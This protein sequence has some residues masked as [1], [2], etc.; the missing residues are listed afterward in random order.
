M[1]TISPPIA[2]AV[3]SLTDRFRGAGALER[4]PITGELTIE[5]VTAMRGTL[6]TIV[7]GLQDDEKVFRAVFGKTGTAATDMKARLVYIGTK[8]M[9]DKRLSDDELV[10]VM[11]GLAV[12][13]VA[14]INFDRATANHVQKIWAAHSQAA[15]T[16]DVHNVGQDIR[17]EVRI[18]NAYPGYAATLDAALWYVL[19]MDAPM[20]R[21]VK[22]TG[23]N[24]GA[25][26]NVFFGGVRSPWTFDWSPEPTL[27]TWG[28][29]WAERF[30]ATDERKVI[31]ALV[32]EALDVI[33]RLQDG[34]VTPPQPPIDEPIDEPVDGPGGDEPP[35]TDEPD[36]PTQR[37]PSPDDDDTGADE[38]PDEDVEDEDPDSDWD[39][40]SESES[41]APDEDEDLDEDD[42]EPETKP[43]G[44]P[45]DED[46]DGDLDEPDEVEEIEDGKADDP[47]DDDGGEGKW[48][49]DK[50]PAEGET[51]ETPDDADESDTFEGVDDPTFRIEDLEFP[52]C[53]GDALKGA[54]DLT[55]QRA[56]DRV[57]ASREE[58]ATR[59][60]KSSNWAPRQARKIW[61]W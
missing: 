2:E 10:A 14:H 4:N 25:A 9:D 55:Y 5:A 51:V 18:R 15:L 46:E 33:E 28:Q 24:A 6:Q 12:H 23:L 32:G 40:P 30:A 61:D 16:H 43:G 59:V 42:D 47:R 48:S 27:L 20:G 39:D 22:A 57:E 41:D 38:D 3:P 45:T 50:A 29:D 11:V 60:L 8:A 58:G 26:R 52:S 54:N 44:D 36:E 7:S 31:T 49:D 56:A 21:T 53:A 37:P 13:E 35:P 34:K 17:I 19:V 1:L